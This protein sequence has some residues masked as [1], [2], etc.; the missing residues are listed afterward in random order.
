MEETIFQKIIKN[1]I[2]SFK[3]YEDSDFLVILDA[4]PK[5][6]GHTLIIFKNEVN[7]NI[8]KESDEKISKSFLLAK[9]IS[10][11]LM[12]KLQTK[13]IKWIVNTGKESGQEIFH[14]HI[15]LIPYYKVNNFSIEKNNFSEIL[16][17]IKN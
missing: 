6:L 1:K 16:K 7:E 13:N 17:I 15:H 9:K 3:I 10:N 12:E 5:N 11:L 8:L 14:T 2:D 4:F